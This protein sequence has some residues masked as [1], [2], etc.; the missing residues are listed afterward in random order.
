VLTDDQR[1]I[2]RELVNVGVGRAGYVLSEMVDS[3]VGLQV[4]EVRAADGHEARKL[5]RLCTQTERVSTVQ[6]TFSGALI[7]SALLAFPSTSARSLVATLTATSSDSPEIDAERE[8]VLTE[9]GNVIIN[10]VLGSL[11]NLVNLDLAFGLPR[12]EEGLPDGALTLTVHG[13]AVIVDVLFQIQSH[14]IEG[15]LALFFEID[16]LASVWRL[17]DPSV[18]SGQVGQP[19]HEAVHA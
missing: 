4:P 8:A 9:V 16:S 17:L 2:L 6:Q 1:D 13:S 15:E 18:P 12:Y 19:G 5:C 3:R 7:G 11:G 10:G 14:S